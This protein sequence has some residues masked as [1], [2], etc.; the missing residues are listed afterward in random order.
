M[1]MTGDMVVTRKEQLF[2]SCGIEYTW[3]TN[4]K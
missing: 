1:G 2:Y 3:Q 4:D